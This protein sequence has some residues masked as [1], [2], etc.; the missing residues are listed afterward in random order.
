MGR[1]Q[2]HDSTTT[3]TPDRNGQWTPG[4]PAH[5]DRG[6]PTLRLYY[7][8]KAVG[9]F[10]I[11]YGRKLRVGRNRDNDI[12]IHDRGVSRH[13]AL[14]GCDLAW[15]V[16]LEDLDSRNG[17]RLN[18]HKITQ[19]TLT[20]GDIIGMGEHVLLFNDRAT[21]QVTQANAADDD[22]MA[23]AAYLQVI[24]GPSQGQRIVLRQR[25]T[26]IGQA[27]GDRIAVQRWSKGYLVSPL[28]GQAP[29]FI[30]DQ[31]IAHNHQAIQDGDIIRFADQSLRFFQRDGT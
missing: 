27:G 9:A 14:I 12:V 17:T 23:L 26:P 11:D 31:R 22:A 19:H 29:L 28:W 15:H 21:R 16:T 5:N 20:Q 3:D 30:N 2:R 25:I 8:G 13:H 24:D 6:A 10:I 7:H 4:T 18:R 1:L